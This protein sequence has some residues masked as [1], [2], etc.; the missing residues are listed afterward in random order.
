MNELTKAILDWHGETARDLPWRGETDP[1]RVYVSE[2]MLQQT[3]TATVKRYYHRFL[4]AFPDPRALADA[5]T[6]QVNKLWEGLGYYARARNL[7]KAARMVAEEMNGRFPDTREGL[8]ALPGCGQYV[9]GAVASI[10]FGR[11]EMALDGNGVRVLSRILGDMRDVTLPPVRRDLEAFGES[12]L[13]DTGAGNFNQALMGM[14]NLVCLPKKA[15]CENCPAAPWCKAYE[16]GKMLEIPVKPPKKAQKAERRLIA[17]VTDGR[18]VW[19]R[20][21]TEAL[22]KGLYEFV[23]LLWPEDKSMEEVLAPLGLQDAP[24]EEIGP[25]E[26]VFTHKIWNMQGWLVKTDSQPPAGYER[27]DGDALRQA[28]M[29]SSMNIYRRAAEEVLE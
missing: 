5:D 24:K 26:H 9:S 17:V 11:R 8:L 14:G 7:Q 1:Y 3:R 19:V 15:L 21:R 12:L 18:Y 25:F 20:K 22:L 27:M 16:M 23:N 29:S 4:D 6:D 13:P 2:I 28:A 10:A